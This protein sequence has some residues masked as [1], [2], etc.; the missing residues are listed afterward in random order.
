MYNLKFNFYRK[1]NGHF[2]N[3]Y[4]ILYGILRI[5]DFQNLL[6]GFVEINQGNFQAFNFNH[7]LSSL[8]SLL[9]DISHTNV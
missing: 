6:D 9:L 2:C 8:F 7:Y 4:I 1:N 3:L 5:T